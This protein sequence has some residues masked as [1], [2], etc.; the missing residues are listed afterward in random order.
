LNI[1]LFTPI[2]FGPEI[3]G[4]RPLEEWRINILG[5]W[6]TGSYDTW[7]G[8]QSVPGIRYN[9][10]WRDYW[11]F[12]LRFSKN[13]NF[14]RANVEL[15]VDIQNVFNFKSMSS[16]GYGF[17]DAKDKLAY[18]RSL[19]LPGN[20]E[21][22]E[23]FGYVNIPGDDQPGD[24]R[25]TGVD[26]VPIIAANNY[27]AVTNPLGTDELYYFTQSAEGF[28]GSGYYEY[29]D[30]GSGI[31]KFQKVAPSRIDQILEDKAYIDM[32]NLTHLTFL[33]PRQIFWGIRLS[34][35]F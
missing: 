27:S 19:H 31:P 21:G 17:V 4:I 25:K 9:V 2:Q 15:F 13:F 24:Y 20:T 18:F 14:G 16:G 5:N 6:R 8:G 33:D 28:H 26:F 11:N 1:D 29:I 22:I 30:D 10:Q 32:P 12:D 23:Q 35:D 34:F 3:A 7:V